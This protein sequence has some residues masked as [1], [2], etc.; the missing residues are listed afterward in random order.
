MD[1]ATRNATYTALAA[2]NPN[3]LLIRQFESLRGPFVSKA[4][5]RFAKVTAEH[6]LKHANIY[7]K[8]LNTE[9][10][11]VVAAIIVHRYTRQKPPPYSQ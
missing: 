10:K 8:R 5:K 1:A 2:F 4:E 9:E 6:I 7:Y 11:Y 3:P